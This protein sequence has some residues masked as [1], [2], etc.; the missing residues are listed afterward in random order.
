MSGELNAKRKNNINGTQMI[1]TPFKEINQT[2][3]H[4]LHTNN[5]K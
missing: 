3:I 2:L 5:S 4:F 1:M